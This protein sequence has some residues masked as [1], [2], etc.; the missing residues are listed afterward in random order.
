MKT[1]SFFYSLLLASLFPLI[2]CDVS[3]TCSGTIT[4]T[5][6]LDGTDIST[7]FS[8]DDVSFSYDVVSSDCS[9]LAEGTTGTEEIDN[10]TRASDSLTFTQDS[11][12]TDATISGTDI[13][14]FSLSQEIAGCNITLTL[15]GS[16]ET[17]DQTI[18]TT[19]SFSAE[20]LSCNASL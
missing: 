19:G 6:D 18:S 14:E 4:A 12:S 11:E 16:I 8:A 15:T 7:T 9:N 10:I 5:Y 13:E 20:G 2:A 3:E 1:K 17:D